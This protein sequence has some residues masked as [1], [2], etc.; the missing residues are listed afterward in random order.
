LVE[1]AS[2]ADA[3]VETAARTAAD[4]VAGSVVAEHVAGTADAHWTPA[5]R[6]QNR[7]RQRPFDL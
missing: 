5:A 3:V 2:D 1:A 6:A 7:Y 4:T